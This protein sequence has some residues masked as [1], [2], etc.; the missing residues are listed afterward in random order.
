MFKI[1]SIVLWRKEGKEGGRKER[2]SDAGKKTG[3]N[4][5][6]LLYDYL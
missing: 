5:T 3:R 6:G 2:K 4:L 1:L